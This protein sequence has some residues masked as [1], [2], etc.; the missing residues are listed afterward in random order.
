VVQRKRAPYLRCRPAKLA[1]ASAA[2]R[3]FNPPK[4]ER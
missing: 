2:A 3:D 1:T 4:V